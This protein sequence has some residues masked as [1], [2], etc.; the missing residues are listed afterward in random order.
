MED[1]LQYSRPSSSV[2]PLEDER[3][4]IN[5]DGFRATESVKLN[6]MSEDNELNI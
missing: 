4:E 3:P 5:S 2:V 6:S 1:S